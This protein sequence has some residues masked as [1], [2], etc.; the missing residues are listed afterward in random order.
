MD[1]LGVLFFVLRILDVFVDVVFGIV[2]E[3]L[4]KWVLVILFF[5]FFFWLK[6]VNRKI[7]S[8][9]GKIIFVIVYC[10]FC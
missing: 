9:F 3:K 5:R 1:K 7:E 6:V 10:V 2:E 4:D 8:L